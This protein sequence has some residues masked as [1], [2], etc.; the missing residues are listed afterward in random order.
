MI[1]QV[2][3]IQKCKGDSVL[4]NTTILTSKVRA[5]LL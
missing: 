2:A 4:D 5:I 1:K 3:I